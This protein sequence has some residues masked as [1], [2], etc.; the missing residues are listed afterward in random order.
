M[1]TP[2]GEFPVVRV[3]TDLTR[4]SGLATLLTKRTLRVGRGVLRLGG[5]GRVAGL[6]VRGR[7]Q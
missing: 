3:A 6:R 2:Y 4:T 7:V 5:D 1:V